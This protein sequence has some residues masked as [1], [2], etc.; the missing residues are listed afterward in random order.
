MQM[1]KLTWRSLAHSQFGER[2]ESDQPII[3]GEGVAI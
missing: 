2:S 1:T 3:G